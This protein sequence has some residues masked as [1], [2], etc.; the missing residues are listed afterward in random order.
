[1]RFYRHLVDAELAPNLLVQP[2]GDD[3]AHHVALAP[4]QG[5][6]AVPQRLHL[7]AVTQ[8][9]P[10]PLRWPPQWRPTAP[11]GRG[12]G[13]AQEPGLEE[14]EVLREVADLEEGGSVTRQAPAG[15]RPGP[16]ATSPACSRPPRCPVAEG[17]Q[18]RAWHG[19]R[20]P[21]RPPG[22]AS[23][24]GQ[25]GMGGSGIGH[26]ARDRRQALPLGH[27]EL[28]RAP[29]ERLEIGMLGI[30]EEHRPPAPSPSR[31]PQYITVTQS[32]TWAT[33]PGSCVMMISPMPV[34]ALEP[35]QEVEDLGLDGD[36]QRRGGLVGDHERRP[37]RR[38]PWRSSPA[39]GGPPTAR[40][41]RRPPSGP[42]R[43]TR[44]RRA[45]R[46]SPSGPRRG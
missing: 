8:P 44:P 15:R 40:R 31:C 32:A 5:G 46:S 30:L 43:G 37:A 42:A 16:R 25:P 17:P 39:G 36:V 18:R 7:Q 24:N 21:A 2:P 20:E 3:Q 19:R 1:M 27:A 28:G 14:G 45:P 12:P 26:R 6:V 9:G 34:L 35:D 4:S 33:T 23:R 22:T 38:G 13:E 11:V 29:E 41:D 10:A